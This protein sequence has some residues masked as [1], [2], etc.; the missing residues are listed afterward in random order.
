[1]ARECGGLE[2]RLTGA[3]DCLQF[4]GR[5][6]GVIAGWLDDESRGLF[7]ACVS[8]ETLCTV[9][10]VEAR[11]RDMCQACCRL[12]DAPA[13]TGD[14]H[15]FLERSDQQM[16]LRL[17]EE[18]RR[19]NESERRPPAQ[20]SQLAFEIMATYLWWDAVSSGKRAL[21]DGPPPLQWVRREMEQL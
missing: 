21:W 17:A 19:A 9:A 5:R 12:D 8:D 20:Q 14:A 13:E 15:L 7:P 2:P 18:L 10:S 3:L 6:A 4:F 1:M 11:L 16:L